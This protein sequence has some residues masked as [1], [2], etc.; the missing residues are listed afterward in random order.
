M[1]SARKAL[2]DAKESQEDMAAK[3]EKAEQETRHLEEKSAGLKKETTEL[4]TKIDLINNALKTSILF[5]NIS[6]SLCTRCASRLSESFDRLKS[7]SY[8]LQEPEDRL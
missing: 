6:K 7:T 2:N 4:T 5:E 3:C 1:T 8:W